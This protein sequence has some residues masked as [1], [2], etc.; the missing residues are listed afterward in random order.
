MI[1]NP[2]TAYKESKYSLKTNKEYLQ[3]LELK[4]AE[5]EDALVNLDNPD[6]YDVLDPNSVLKSNVE[7]GL[8]PQDAYIQAKTVSEFNESALNNRY[9]ELNNKIGKEVG[10]ENIDILGT[11]TQ[12]STLEENGEIT[13][14]QKELKDRIEANGQIPKLVQFKNK[15]DEQTLAIEAAYPAEKN[16]EKAAREYQ[17][18]IDDIDKSGMLGPVA[19]IGRVMASTGV[20][21]AESI[22]AMENTLQNLSISL[23]GKMIPILG[24]QS[25]KVYNYNALVDRGDKVGAAKFLMDL[26][27]K[28]NLGYKSLGI[29]YMQPSNR[30]ISPLAQIVTKD[31]ILYETEDGQVTAVRDSE[32]YIIP[33]PSEKSFHRQE[34]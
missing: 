34:K 32:G 4:A 14:E 8:I 18:A 29:K 6:R 12:L 7:S 21:V 9:Y 19:E 22:N 25:A 2:E 27:E 13:K 10:L 3:D 33:E 16:L 11:F 30:Q 23:T 26:E 31:D 28:E 15:L 17:I 24:I 20:K 5:Y 1:E